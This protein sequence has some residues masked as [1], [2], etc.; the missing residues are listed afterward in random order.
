MGK[1][2]AETLRNGIGDGDEHD[3]KLGRISGDDTAALRGRT[4]W[5]SSDRPGAVGLLS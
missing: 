5:P 1:A 3:W 2:R 4:P